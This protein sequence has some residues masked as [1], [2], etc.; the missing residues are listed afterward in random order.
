MHASINKG[1]NPN[2]ALLKAVYN[3]RT[4]D[5]NFDAEMKVFEEMLSLLSEK[6]YNG[7]LLNEFTKNP[8]EMNPVEFKEFY[9]DNIKAYN[10]ESMLISES[11][12]EENEI[13]QLDT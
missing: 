1:E 13:N 6:M 12:G 4:S 9:S 11:A 5:D 10:D 2:I 7:L 8:Y 3:Y